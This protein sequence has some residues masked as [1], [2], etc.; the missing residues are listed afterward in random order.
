MK[1]LRVKGLMWQ[2]TTYEV[3][4]IW[5]FSKLEDL[6]LHYENLPHDLADFLSTMA[7]CNL[8][9]L[10]D[11]KILG[12]CYVPFGSSART[13]EHLA[14][15]LHD[16]TGLRRIIMQHFAWRQFMPLKSLRL[17]SAT[18]RSLSIIT[19]DFSPTNPQ[20]SP[21]ELQ[22]INIW[23]PNLAVLGFTASSD[24]LA[25]SFQNLFRR[26]D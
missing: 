22:D 15:L 19:F 2:Y 14:G 17:V 24:G 16:V 25:V 12:S 26:V 23:C 6:E 20:L 13:G 18:L 3:S 8:D 5:D 11:L 9:K 4:R 7:A 10:E 1:K 21:Q